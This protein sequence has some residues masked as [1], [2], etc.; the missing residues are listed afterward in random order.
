VP[1]SGLAISAFRPDDLHNSQPG[2]FQPTIEIVLPGSVSWTAG[3]LLV[4]VS[5]LV[6]QAVLAVSVLVYEHLY[7]NVLAFSHSPISMI[8]VITLYVFKSSVE[9]KLF[10]A[11]AHQEIDFVIII[12]RMI[13]SSRR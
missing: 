3:L 4:P 9:K 5:V 8:I 7:V 2:S 10:F 6:Q 1:E 11:F 13:R 12:Y